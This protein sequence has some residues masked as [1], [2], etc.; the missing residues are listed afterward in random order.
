MPKQKKKKEKKGSSAPQYYPCAFCGSSFAHFDLWQSIR[1][2]HIK[3][4]STD[5]PETPHKYKYCCYYC[6]ANFRI[7]EEK[8]LTTKAWWK[9]TADGWAQLVANVKAEMA[10]SKRK[11]HKH[12][13]QIYIEA[14]AEINAEEFET[15]AN[16]R[17]TLVSV[18]HD[19]IAKQLTQNFSNSNN[20]R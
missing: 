8:D 10:E 16:K 15:R 6:E 20:C 2:E 13:R 1:E 19:K 11:R 3:E 4:R 9:D 12:R 5:C 14:I 7:E 17:S 18:F